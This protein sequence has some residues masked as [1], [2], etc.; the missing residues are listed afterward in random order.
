VN[1]G[2]NVVH[3]TPRKE[4][5]PL[6]NLP[7]SLSSWAQ[8]YL[9]LAVTGVRADSS[10]QKVELHLSRFITFFQK[11]YGHERISTVLPR[12]V[13]AWRDELDEKG[14]QVEEGTWQPLARSTVNNHLASLSGFCSWVEKQ[15]PDLFHQ[16]N[17]TKGIGE[18]G[19]PPLTVRALSE[20][21]VRSL[22]SVCDRLDRFYRLKGRRWSGQLPPL[23]AHARPLRDRA[24]IFTLLSTGLRREEL[25]KLDLDQL[26]P[27]DPEKL[28]KA[29]KA[30]LTR[31]RGK[32]KSE[33]EVF[34]SVDA[35]D[36]L[37]DYIEKE[38]PQDVTEEATA[39]FLTAI[40]LPARKPDGRMSKDAINDVC[41]RIGRL[42]DGEIPDPDRHISPLRPHDLRH[43]FGFLLAKKTGADAYEL[44]RRLGH[45]SDRYIKVY[46]NPPEEVAAEYV[47]DL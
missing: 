42:H 30:K 20:D 41:L 45:R 26:V 25:I 47:E 1:L 33:R 9:D 27:N 37:S 14:V 12:D 3:F 16:G 7:D 36:A 15:A 34:L 6:A 2:R 24:I 10:V 5:S 13:V 35:R 21:Q 38:R 39:L 4:K 8:A 44:E 40:G 19:T 32:N 46:T 29:K 23:R 31:V 28:R 18:L 17:P 11:R 22:K 43:T